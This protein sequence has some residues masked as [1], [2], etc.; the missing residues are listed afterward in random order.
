MDLRRLRYFVAV[1]RER[2][3]TRAAQLL[4]MAQPPLSRQIRLLEEEVGAEL[5]DRSSR[6]L[7]L[8]EAGRLLHEQA[9]QVLA[10][11]E[12]IQ[13]MVGRLSDQGGRRFVIG[14]VGSTLYGLLPQVIRRFREESISADVSLL[15]CSSVEQITALKEGRIDVGFGRLRVEDPAVRRIV[16]ADEPLVAAVPADHHLV[17][18]GRAVH[19]SELLVEPL[20]VYP[21]PARPSY[22]DQ[23]LG[24]IH[25]LG[26]TPAKIMEV[27]E[28]QTA[29]GLVAAYAGFAV[30]PESVQRLRRD[31]V[32]YLPLA[33]RGA[34]S[35]IMMVHRSGDVTPEL[36]TLIRISCE[37]HASAAH[38]HG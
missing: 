35:P 26:L 13:S 11:M 8:T 25:D 31:D 29:I 7:K 1:A 15:E 22:A 17:S 23:V 10:G 32:R 5:V 20:I 3:F 27:R 34:R 19:L 38:G 16:L 28:L 18:V 37:I 30:V 36:A 33:D 6:P 2:N 4:N 12:Q 21:R 9:V 14:F 24:V